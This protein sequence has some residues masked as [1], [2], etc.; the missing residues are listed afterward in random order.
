MPL[1]PELQEAKY[2]MIAA[3]RQKG[4]SVGHPDR[5]QVDRD[6]V[7]GQLRL[8]VQE[9]AE[10]TGK[11]GDSYTLRGTSF[12]Q[13]PNGK[14]TYTGLYTTGL[15]EVKREEGVVGE[16]QSSHTQKLVDQMNNTH[17]STERPL[18]G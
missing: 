4:I 8:N 10:F 17:T 7:S 11:H 18:L 15:G 14:I 16:L 2:K 13:Q 9:G 12:T 5:V 6:P 3:L 1:S